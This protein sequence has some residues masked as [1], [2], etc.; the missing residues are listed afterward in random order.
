[1]SFLLIKG[2]LIFFPLGELVPLV[3]RELTCLQVMYHRLID[4]ET[5]SKMKQIAEFLRVLT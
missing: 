5:A 4:F 2:L 3:F 1:M